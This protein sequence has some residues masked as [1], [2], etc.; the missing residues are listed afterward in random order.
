MPPHDEEGPKFP[1]LLLAALLAIVYTLGLATL[2][3][4]AVEKI[5]DWFRK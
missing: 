1:R 2:L 4:G 3:S 5:A